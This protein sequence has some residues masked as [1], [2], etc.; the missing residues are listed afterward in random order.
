[1]ALIYN[2]QLINAINKSRPDIV[3]NFYV[4]HNFMDDIKKINTCNFNKLYEYLLIFLN[5]YS[6]GC[7]NTQFNQELYIKQHNEHLMT[8]LCRSIIS[9]C[10]TN[11]ENEYLEKV[12]KHFDYT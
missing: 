8:C 6:K 11:E 5:E 9:I 3:A 4:I 10:F 7:I 1:M 2:S 12:I